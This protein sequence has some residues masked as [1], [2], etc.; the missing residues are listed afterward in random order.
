MHL[1]YGSFCIKNDIEKSIIFLKKS[2]SL[3]ITVKK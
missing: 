2:R 1:M 3:N